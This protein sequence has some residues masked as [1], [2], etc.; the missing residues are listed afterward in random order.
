MRFGDT[1]G[2]IAILGAVVVSISSVGGA[3]AADPQ[4]FPVQPH[5]VPVLVAAVFV[6]PAAM[7]GLMSGIRRRQ[8]RGALLAIGLLRRHVRGHGLSGLDARLRINRSES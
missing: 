6:L 1:C 8:G 2:A 3:L 7:A 5:L 4:V